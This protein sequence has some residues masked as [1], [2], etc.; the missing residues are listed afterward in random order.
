MNQKIYDGMKQLYLNVESYSKQF[1]KRTYETAFLEEYEMQRKLFDEIIKECDAAENEQE[2]IEKISKIIPDMMHEELN[3]L[4]NKRKKEQFLMNRNMGMVSFVIPMLRYGRNATLDEICERIIELWNE[5][6]AGMSISTTTYENIKDGFKF[7][8]C[9]ITTAVCEGLG[10]PDDCY[11]LTLLRDYR[12]NYLAKT[13]S[14]RALVQ[15]YYDIAPTI[16]KRISRQE[17]AEDIYMDIWN[18]YLK[19]CVSL[20]EEGKEEE[21]CETY[22]DMVHS[23]QGKYLFS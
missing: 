9:Y 6:D 16:V 19:P 18:Q 14:G 23:L 22:T 15:E 11:E 12:D 13:D 2:F 8:L 4:P 1:D 3:A 17:N 7:H 10:K 21:C 5:H 20:I